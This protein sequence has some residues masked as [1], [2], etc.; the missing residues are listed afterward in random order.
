MSSRLIQYRHSLNLLMVNHI[1]TIYSYTTFATCTQLHTVY[2][3]GS[4]TSS[5]LGDEISSTGSDD[6]EL[7]TPPVYCSITCAVFV[8]SC[9][10]VTAHQAYTPGQYIQCALAQQCSFTV[11]PPASL[12][13]QLPDFS[14]SMAVAT[15][16]GIGV[17][18]H[19]PLLLYCTLGFSQRQL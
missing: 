7:E 6:D 2:A 12:C 15:G 18:I 4:A 10:C 1:S 13:Y 5:T 3:A 19:C 11:S 14:I 17:H 8:S 16:M 9:T